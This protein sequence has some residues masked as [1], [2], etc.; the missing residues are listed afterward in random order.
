MEK[1]KD[2]VKQ[3]EKIFPDYFE[4]FTLPEGAHEES[5]KVYRA[6]RSGRCDKLSF[7]P[8]YEQNGFKTTNVANELEPGEF[9]LSTFEK[10]NH[11]KRWANL[12]SDMKV[13]FKIAIGYTNPIHGVIQRTSER[14]PK[15]KSH[16][17]WW[18]YKDAEPYK[19]FELIPDFDAHLQTYINKRDENNE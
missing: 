9:S 1:T 19:E 12:D 6:C 13:P 8:T 5:I 2:A 14:K 15:S 3:I 17:D 10:P 18:L 4:K 7:L 16:V 11:I